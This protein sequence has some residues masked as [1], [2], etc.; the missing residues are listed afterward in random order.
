MPQ[1]RPLASLRKTAIAQNLPSAR[2]AAIV[3]LPVADAV[4]TITASDM[5]PTPS[6]LPLASHRAEPVPAPRASPLARVALLA[7][8]VLLVYGSLSP[9]TGWRSLGVGPLEFVRAPW[10]AYVTGFDLTLNVLAYAPLGLLLPLALHPRLRGLPAF[11][12]AVGA[13]AFLSLGIEGLQNYLPA[14]IASNLDVLTNVAGASLGA[15]AATV[16]A[17]TLIDGRQVQLARQRWF[18]PRSAVLL[19]LVALWPMAQIHPGPMLF[20][21]GELDREL[22]AALLDLANRR[23]PVFDAG[24][25]AAA[26]VLV[27]ACGM[28]AAGAA[29]SAA[30]KQDAPRLRLL[31]LLLA[32]ALGTKAI[33]YGHEFGPERALAWL[34]PGAVA[35]LAIGLL[36]VTVA[37]TA[38]SAHAASTLSAAALLVLVVAVNAVPP[39]PYHAHWLAAW[40]PGRLRDLAAATDWL[41][42]AWP[43]VTLAALLWALPLRRRPPGQPQDARA[44]HSGAS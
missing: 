23:L 5:T 3:A 19:L 7:Y 31:L 11:A 29:L 33:A 25:F 36:A 39:N 17:P 35:G 18:R 41:A 4:T 8:I 27:T 1:A 38:A 6:R 34:T 26:E 16:L 20:G 12:T 40:Q 22:I 44:F 21:N 9:W 43:Y 10:P 28:L 42:Q 30:T 24:Q 13:A 2:G 37:A 32:A 15:L 14:R